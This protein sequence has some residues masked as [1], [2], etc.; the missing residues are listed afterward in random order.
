MDNLT[1]T[2]QQVLALV[3]KGATNREIAC[4][5]SAERGTNM[6]EKTV[7]VHVSAIMKAIKAPNRTTAALLWHGLPT[8]PREG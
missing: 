5:L 4:I 2:Q 6:T 8:L 1:F 7:K 3:A